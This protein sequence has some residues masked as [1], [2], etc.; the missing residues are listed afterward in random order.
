[1]RVT[2]QL[3]S[4]VFVK[5]MTLTANNNIVASYLTDMQGNVNIFHI[6]KGSDN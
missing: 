2:D 4:I 6:F 3:K 1:M 5:L